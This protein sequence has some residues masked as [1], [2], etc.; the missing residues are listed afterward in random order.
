[1]KYNSDCPSV[2]YQS[3]EEGLAQKLPFAQ[4]LKVVM[5]LRRSSRILQLFFWGGEQVTPRDEI[6]GEEMG[7]GELRGLK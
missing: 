3:L 2:P 7:Q 6:V 4:R 1:M 5:S